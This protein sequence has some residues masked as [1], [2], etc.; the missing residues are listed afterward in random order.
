MSSN[1]LAPT[2]SELER[3]WGLVLDDE[4]STD[5]GRGDLAPI[6]R[7]FGLGAA[8]QR[9]AVMAR[10]G[11]IPSTAKS[12]RATAST[13]NARTETAATR[14]SFK[15]AYAQRPVVHRSGAMP[16][17]S[18][19][20][21][22][23]RAR[24]ALAPA[25]Q[26]PLAAQRRGSLGSLG[27][28]RR[29]RDPELRDA[30]D[31]LRSASAPEPLRPPQQRQGRADRKAHAGA[32]GRGRFR[33]LAR[34]VDRPRADLLRHLRQDDLEADPAPSASRRTTALTPLD[35]SVSEF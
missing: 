27:R 4:W 21:R 29:P 11:M 25:P 1:F 15:A 19:L 33:R 13:V 32:A 35:T 26:R 16:V 8:A 22:R 14:P 20:H 5:V 24:R 7:R 17:R 18:V 23:Q 9:Q 28:R 6:I 10:F 3:D 34:R 2:P 12:A 31:Q 30:D